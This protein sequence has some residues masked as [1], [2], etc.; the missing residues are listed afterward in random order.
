MNSLVVLSPIVLGF[1]VGRNTDMSFVKKLNRPPWQPPAWLFGPVWTVLYVMMG[2]ASFLVLRTGDTK[3]VRVALCVYALQLSVN[4]LWPAIFAKSIFASLIV[5]SML[6]G[7]IF[8]TV[9]LFYKI[10]RVAGL[11]LLP[12]LLW[13]LFATVLT[14]TLYKMN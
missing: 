3:A 2:I 7:L 1:L 8:V 11:L 4:L 6:L 5:I 13:V 12:Y 9:V 14:A 10:N